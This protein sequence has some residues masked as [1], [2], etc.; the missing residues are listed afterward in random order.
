MPGS[1]IIAEGKAYVIGKT[2]NFLLKSSIL[3]FFQR[4]DLFRSGECLL[5]SRAGGSVSEGAS[6]AELTWVA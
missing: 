5:Q 4:F 2:G 6:D 1:L 3:F